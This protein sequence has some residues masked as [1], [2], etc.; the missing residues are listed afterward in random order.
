MEMWDNLYDFHVIIIRVINLSFYFVWWS[1]TL[2]SEKLSEQ[3]SE[4]VGQYVGG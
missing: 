4:Q 3:G 1:W 2:A